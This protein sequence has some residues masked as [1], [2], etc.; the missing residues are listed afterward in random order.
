MFDCSLGIMTEIGRG[1]VRSIICDSN[2]VVDVVPVDF[3]V[4]TL[5]CAAW[6][7]VVQ[8]TDTIQV[9]NCT[10]SAVHPIT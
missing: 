4:N 2:L 8:R 10:S 9:Y 3:V 7:N 5:I 6:H 1:T